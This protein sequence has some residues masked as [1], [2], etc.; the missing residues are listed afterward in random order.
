[1][2]K[3]N[4]NK[5][6]KG[7]YLQILLEPIGSLSHS[8]VLTLT[9]DK[10]K[11]LGIQD[12]LI[13]GVT[14]THNESPVSYGIFTRDETNL[15]VNQIKTILSASIVNAEQRKAVEFLID[16]VIRD[17]QFATANWAFRRTNEVY[18]NAEEASGDAGLLLAT[19]DY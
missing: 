14:W 2:D 11:A 5:S 3:N 16:A 7:E 13:A 19:K 18:N 12:H 9:E 15:M 4:Q 17:R 10:L 8:T 6:P 1:M